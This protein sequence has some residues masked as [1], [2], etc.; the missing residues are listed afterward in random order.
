M[1]VRKARIKMVMVI[2]RDEN[3][4]T[5]FQVFHGFPP[6]FQGFNLNFSRFSAPISFNS[7]P[8]LEKAV[9]PCSSG[10]K[11]V[12]SDARCARAKAEASS[13]I[14]RG[15]LGT[16]Y[17]SVIYCIYFC[18]SDSLSLSLSLYIYVWLYIHDWGCSAVCP[19]DMWE[20]T[21][22]FIP[23]INVVNIFFHGGN[24]RWIFLTS[25]I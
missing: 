19:L 23:N 13:V 8:S 10:A 12:S 4:S 6:I 24:F 16:P 2:L 14:K 17:I 18:N 7:L 1:A 21:F 11:P 3:L 5:Q 22:E 25:I 15:Y 20:R 9:R